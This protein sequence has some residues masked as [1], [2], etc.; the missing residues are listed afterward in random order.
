MILEVV[1]IDLNSYK[2]TF[3]FDCKISTPDYIGFFK[4][5]IIT[6]DKRYMFYREVGLW[7]GNKHI[8]ND[9]L[10]HLFKK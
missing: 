5:S 2:V 7:S 10:L 6:D 1:K 3:L 4:A 8:R 9:L